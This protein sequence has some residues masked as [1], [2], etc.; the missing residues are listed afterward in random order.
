MSRNVKWKRANIHSLLSSHSSK[1]LLGMG[2]E[3]ELKPSKK[4]CDGC[5]DI[6]YLAES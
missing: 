2:V 1:D 5:G 6:T 3:G 4:D